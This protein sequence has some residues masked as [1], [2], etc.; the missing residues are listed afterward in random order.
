[1]QDKSNMIE[2]T[3]VNSPLQMKNLITPISSGTRYENTIYS[4]NDTI[5]IPAYCTFLIKGLRDL[6]VI[7]GKMEIDFT[8]IIRFMKKGLPDFLVN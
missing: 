4:V 1:M 8:L 7:A 3:N 2:L 5:I 6:D